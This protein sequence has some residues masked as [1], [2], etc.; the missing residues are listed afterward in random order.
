MGAFLRV[1]PSE[2]QAIEFRDRRWY[3]ASTFELLDRVGVGLCLHDMP[4]SATTPRPIGP[5]VYLRFHGAG[6]KYGGSYSSQRLSAWAD[7]IARWAWDGTPVWAYFNNDA[8][9]YAIRDAHRLRAFVAK[10]LGS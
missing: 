8:A 10:R 5:L 6:A 7:R 2:P 3:V 1:V 4:G 9:A